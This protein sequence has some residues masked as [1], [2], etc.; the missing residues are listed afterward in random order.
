MTLTGLSVVEVAVGASELGLGHAGGVPGWVFAELGAT[1]TRVVGTS[2]PD[3]DADVPW[4]R[5]W[6]RR[7]RVV[8]TDDPAGILALLGDAD[9]AFVYG[10]EAVVEERG[11]GREAVLAATPNLIY[12]RCHGDHALL[13]E[14]GSG[15]CRQLA[16]HRKGPM[17]VD[18]RA[19]TAGTALLLT[20]STLA[21]LRRRAITGAGGWTET[22]LYD[23]MLAT[24]G[25]MIGRSERAAPKIEQYWRE[26]SFFPNFLYRCGDGE[27]IQVWF[28]GKGMYAAI[29]DVLGDEPS[30]DGYYAEQTNGGLQARAERWKSIFPTRPRAEWVDLI[31]AAG[32]ACEEVLGPGEAL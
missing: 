31:R 11:L 15:F 8:V 24:L 21:L 3:I 29:I 22:S 1:V 23:G 4:G 19:T 5:V 6:H 27:L 30:E 12:A 16:A 18:A 13:V 7:K 17:L 26:G 9:V 2:T 14:A 20:V 25:C 32:V 10:S 28:G